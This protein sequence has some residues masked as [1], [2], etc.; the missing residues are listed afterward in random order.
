M[1]LFSSSC[2]SSQ[3][4]SGGWR[5]LQHWLKLIALLPSNTS[6]NT[7]TAGLICLKILPG[8]APPP[9]PKHV[10]IHNVIIYCM[11]QSF[12]LVQESTD[13]DRLACHR[14]NVPP[15]KTKTK[16]FVCMWTVV[17]DGEFCSVLWMCLHVHIHRKP[18]LHHYTILAL[19]ESKPVHLHYHIRN[20]TTSHPQGPQDHPITFTCFTDKQLHSKNIHSP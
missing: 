6:T 2:H 19:T 18:L 3:S 17:N 8:F 11:E 10:L 12:P 7:T 14:R 5:R 16:L 13:F 15:D 9:F 4:P 1:D 20:K